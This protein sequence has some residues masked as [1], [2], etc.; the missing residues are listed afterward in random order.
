MTPRRR[1]Y[2]GQLEDVFAAARGDPFRLCIITPRAAMSETSSNCWKLSVGFFALRPGKVYQ[3]ATVSWKPSE[4]H[5]SMKNCAVFNQSEFLVNEIPA[6]PR[7]K[8][9]APRGFDDVME[10]PLFFDRLKPNYTFPG[11][12]AKNPNYQRRLQDGSAKQG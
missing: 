9:V 1:K 7:R 12:R 4:H 6:K 5:V 2:A 8:R 11:R 10:K 3:A